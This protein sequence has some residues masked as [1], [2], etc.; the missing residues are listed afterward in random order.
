MKHCKFSNEIV[1]G[2]LPST[3]WCSISQ[4]SIGEHWQTWGI[5]GMCTCLSNQHRGDDGITEMSV[6]SG[7]SP[8]ATALLNGVPWGFINNSWIVVTIP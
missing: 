4:P 6:Q 8:W 3:N 5:S 1:M 2:C 7:K